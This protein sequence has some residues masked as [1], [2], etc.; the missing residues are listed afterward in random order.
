MAA[1]LED[2]IREARRQV[3]AT[4]DGP[5]AAYRAAERRLAR[6]EQQQAGQR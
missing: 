1:T 5:I 6:L 4:Y 3:R 2:R